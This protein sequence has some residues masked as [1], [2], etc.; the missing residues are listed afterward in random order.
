MKSTKKD[1]D[2]NDLIS[3]TVGSWGTLTKQACM[4]HKSI[5]KLFAIH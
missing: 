3:F 5:V 1:L 2:H 4:Q